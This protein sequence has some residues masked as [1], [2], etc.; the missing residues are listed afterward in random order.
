MRR[1]G[2]AWISTWILLVGC[3]AAVAQDFGKFFENAAKKAIKDSLTPENI[4]RTIKP[5]T[6]GEPY[7]VKTA[8]GW[9]L[10]AHRYRPRGQAKPGTLPVILCHGLTYNALFWDLDPAVSLARYLSAAGHDVWVVSL[11]GCGLS[12]KWVWKLDSAPT[13][14][15]G[16]AIRRMTGGKVAPTGYATV[17]PRFADYSLDDH[18]AQDLPAFVRLVQQHTG[19][20]QVAWVGH[21][22]GGIIPIAHL[23]RF[24]N[25]G[26][27]RLVTVGSQVTMPEGQVVVEFLAEMVRNRSLQLAGQMTPEQVM[28]A[29][30]TSVNNLFFNTG[31]VSRQV[32]DALTGWAVD[33]PS[34]GLMKQYMTLATKGELLD[35]TKRYSYARNL[36]NVNVPILISCGSMD[37]FAPPVVQQFL[38]DNV[39]ST[40]KTLIVFGRAQGFAVDAGHDDALVGLNS[41][42]QVYPIIEQWLSTPR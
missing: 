32:Y 10:V 37:R 8:D 4:E 1:H 9:N 28:E 22:M 5:H 2:W 41:R 19:S 15:V 16:G 25:P 23:A 39:G 17:D 40:D 3:Q 29:T 12:Q 24:K 6:S 30:R 20:P 26:I 33:V 35:A 11:R 36:A 18:I 13:M 7:T 21:S 42:A 27:G 38:H 34:A 14:L 31:N